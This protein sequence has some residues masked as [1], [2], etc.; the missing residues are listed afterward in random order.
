MGEDLALL[1]QYAIA[2]GVGALVVYSAR[3]YRTR[4]DALLVAA[5]LVVISSSV[6]G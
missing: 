2:F 5:A 3:H 4:F 1:I 6:L